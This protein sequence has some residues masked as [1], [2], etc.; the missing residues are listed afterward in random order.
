MTRRRLS[1]SPVFRASS[2]NAKNSLVRC[3][4]LRVGRL[5]VF[6]SLAG[7]VED[8]NDILEARIAFEQTKD[9]PSVPWEET[10]PVA[11]G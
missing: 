8:M 1:I 2:I 6:F 11:N 5:R 9:E 10:R 4:G 7:N 3:P